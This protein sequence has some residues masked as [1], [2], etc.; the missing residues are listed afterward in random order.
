VCVVHRW[1][2]RHSDLGDRIRTPS[3]EEASPRGHLLSPVQVKKSRPRCHTARFRERA[4]PVPA[5]TQLRV[6]VCL[7]TWLTKGIFF[8]F[9]CSHCLSAVS[10]LERSARHSLV[11]S[12]R[13]TRPN[14]TH[15]TERE[16]PSTMQLTATAF[17][18]RR[19]ADK[20]SVNLSALKWF[21]RDPAPIPNE[22]DFIG[23]PAF[24]LCC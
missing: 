19:V 23:P 22:I 12:F 9:F 3:A 13:P 20:V 17:S 10:G 21:A 1:P 18:S 5:P 2:P 6:C 14:F 15:T 11:A 8:F 7:L 16:G 24:L 4:R